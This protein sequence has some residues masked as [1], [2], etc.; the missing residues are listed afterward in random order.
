MKKI[1]ARKYHQRSINAYH[2]KYFGLNMARLGPLH[3]NEA[4]KLM[5][6]WRRNVYAWQNII[7]MPQAK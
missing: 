4:R 3:I 7:N 6:K 2:S 5:V 1:K